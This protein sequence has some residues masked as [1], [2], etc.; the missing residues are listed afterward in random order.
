MFASSASKIQK[1]DEAV[2]NIVRNNL[3]DNCKIQP[4]TRQEVLV[5]WL[6]GEVFLYANISGEKDTA[7]PGIYDVCVAKCSLLTKNLTMNMHI[8]T[9]HIP[10]VDS[11]GGEQE[12]AQAAVGVAFTCNLCVTLWEGLNDL[13]KG[14]RKYTR[15]IVHS[16][17]RR[18]ST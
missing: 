14:L 7:M 1:H 16:A 8:R 17:L 12:A 9:H 13:Y 11:R 4:H 18:G 2:S 15:L 10:G 6:D 5:C 3:G